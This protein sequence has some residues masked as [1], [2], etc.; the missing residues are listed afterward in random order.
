MNKRFKLNFIWLFCLFLAL[1]SWAKLTP[2][3][4][5]NKQKGILLFNQSRPNDNIEKLLLIAAEADDIEAMV[6]LGIVYIEQGKQGDPES[7]YIYYKFTGDL[8][9]LI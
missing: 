1:P 8:N 5:Q 9:W 4:E 2:E 7:M 6:Y 3:Q